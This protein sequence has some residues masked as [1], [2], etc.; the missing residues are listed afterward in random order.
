MCFTVDSTMCID[1]VHLTWINA[2]LNIK[3]AY[4]AVLR[5]NIL[6]ELVNVLRVDNALP[7]FI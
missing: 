1:I 6:M 7:R 3:N 5:I 2:F 4:K